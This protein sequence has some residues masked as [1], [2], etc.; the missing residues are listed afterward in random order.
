MRKSANGKSLWP[1]ANLGLGRAGLGL[2]LAGLWPVQLRV[3]KRPNPPIPETICNKK[4]AGIEQRPGGREAWGSLVHADGR[5]Y[6]TDRRGTTVVFAAGPKCE[7]LAT[8]PLGE[9][10]DAS[11]AVSG[12]DLFIRTHKHLWCIGK[13]K[14]PREERP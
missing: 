12:G 5:V 6:V 4:G 14:E 7:H 8:N 1:T 11:I 3:V 9:H 10:T 13:V 2:I